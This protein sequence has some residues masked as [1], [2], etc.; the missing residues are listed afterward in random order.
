LLENRGKKSAGSEKE[1]SKLGE[2]GWCGKLGSFGIFSYFEV[3]DFC[4][5]GVK[6]H[7][8]LRKNWVRFGG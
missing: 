3:R 5:F 1:D 6:R 2:N 8:W 4:V 7:I